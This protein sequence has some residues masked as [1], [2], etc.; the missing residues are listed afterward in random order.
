MKGEFNCK[1]IRYL[2]HRN[3]ALRF[4][5]LGTEYHGYQMQKK[6]SLKTVEKELKDILGIN[7]IIIF[8]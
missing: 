4:G 3:F 2:N 1:D 7:K 6:S 5:Y 8:K